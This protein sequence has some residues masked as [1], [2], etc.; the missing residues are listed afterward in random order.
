VELT[1]SNFKV[2]SPYNMPKN[3][4]YSYDNVT[5]VRTFLVY[6]GDNGSVQPAYKPSFSTCLFSR[7]NIFL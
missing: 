1:E 4:R 5:G 3:K 6:P 2:Q 7:N